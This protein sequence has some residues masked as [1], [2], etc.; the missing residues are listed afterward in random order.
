MTTFTT[1][2][3]NVCLVIGVA[4]VLFCKQV[5]RT[6]V[7]LY[8]KIGVEVSED[9]YARQVRWVGIAFIILGGAILSSAITHR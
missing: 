8:K 5:G 9:T 7:Q 6:G 1:V 3:G 4:L 2:F